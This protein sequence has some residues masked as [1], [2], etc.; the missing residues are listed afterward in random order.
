MSAKH[1]W[2]RKGDQALIGMVN[3]EPKW[4]ISGDGGYEVL[5]P[6]RY[7][8]VGYTSGGATT[9]PVP[10]TL[11]FTRFGDQVFLGIE[12][13]DF[14]SAAQTGNLQFAGGQ[15]PAEYLPAT[16]IYLPCVFMIAGPNYYAGLLSIGVTGQINFYMMTGAAD[17]LEQV[18]IVDLE[19]IQLQNFV[20]YYSVAK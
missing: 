5:N 10:M 1:S 18:V 6:L 3:D 9:I 19:H 2:I 4:R 13:F 15:F 11:E 8:I 17:D 16:T 12:G 14:T 7:S 20:G